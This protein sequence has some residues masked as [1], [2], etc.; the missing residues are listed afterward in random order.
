MLRLL[1][2]DVLGDSK[3]M[4]ENAR[5]QYFCVHCDAPL[6]ETQIEMT[7]YFSTSTISQPKMKVKTYK[8]PN[9]KCPSGGMLHPEESSGQLK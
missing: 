5:K 1:M 4:T 3:R 8:C 9:L 2:D 6:E 7:D